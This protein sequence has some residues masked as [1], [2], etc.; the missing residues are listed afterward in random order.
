MKKIHIDA[1]VKYD[2]IIS[3]G[4]LESCGNEILKVIPKSRAALVSDD[5]VFS[6]YGEKVKKS[7]EASGFEVVCHTFPN[8][9][10]SKNAATYI[11]IL[12]FL[13]ENKLTRSDIAVAL[14]GGV[15]GDM[16]G[17]AAATYLRGIKFVQ[18]PTTFLAAVDSSVGGKTGINLESGKNLA[19]AFHQPSLVICDTDTFDTLAPETFSD[20]VSEAIKCG[21]IADAALF[22]KMSGDFKEN[23]EEIIASCVSIKRDVV[24]CDEF[25]TG[26]R[27]LL[28]YGHTIGHAIEKCSSF[29]VTHGHAVA[30]GMAIITNAAEKIGFCESGTYE[31]LIGTLEKCGL[32]T[33][34]PYGA[35]ELYSVTLSDKK[36]SGNSVTLVLPQKIGKCVLHKVS[37]EELLEYIKKGLEK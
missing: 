8:G 9:E 18:I 37:T 3:H 32:P 30:I 4:I 33:E 25:D 23:I 21:M 16:V 34:C 36:R 5:K 20:G 26:A 13:A 29:S 11:E 35:E 17:F 14:G 27:Q 10:K 22:E 19:G 24:C 28:N 6:L 12:E 31:K 2:V 7:L 1:S 15:T